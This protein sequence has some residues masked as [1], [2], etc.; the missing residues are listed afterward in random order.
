MQ[1]YVF[2]AVSVRNRKYGLLQIKL[3]EPVKLEVTNSYCCES[4]VEK[5]HFT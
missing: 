1:I 3:S 5:F 4:F 2:F